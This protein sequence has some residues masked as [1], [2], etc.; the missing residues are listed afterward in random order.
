MTVSYTHLDVYKRQL[1]DQPIFNQGLLPLAFDKPI[2]NYKAAAASFDPPR[3]F[4]FPGTHHIWWAI[5]YP[6]PGEA[7]GGWL[8][9]SHRTNFITN[10]WF[11]K[12]EK[13]IEND[14]SETKT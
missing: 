2:C 1:Q 5:P 11:C 3:V 8:A 4:Y 10:F 9:T 6:P 12:T 13:E 14:K 7:L